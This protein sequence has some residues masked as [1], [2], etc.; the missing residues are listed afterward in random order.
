MAVRPRRSGRGAIW[1]WLGLGR[2]RPCA[3]MGRWHFEFGYFDGVC[4]CADV[5]PRAVERRRPRRILAAVASG[6]SDVLFTLLLAFLG[7]AGVQSE[8]A[9][10]RAG[11]VIPP[12]D[13][14]DI[15]SEL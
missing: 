6:R 13:R 14:R 10:D 3:K 12:H 1:H 4:V 9:R 5:L 7:R 8:L 2:T 15:D 11:R